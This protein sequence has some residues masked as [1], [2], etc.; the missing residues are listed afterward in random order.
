MLSI[1][2]IVTS[3]MLSLCLVAISSDSVHAQ[4]QDTELT[5]TQKTSET[6]GATLV[7]FALNAHVNIAV[8][9]ESYHNDGMESERANALIQMNIGLLDHVGPAVIELSKYDESEG[10]D[11]DFLV[12]IAKAFKS[13]KAEAVALAKY[14]ESEDDADH[15]EFLKLQEKTQAEIDKMLEK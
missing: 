1:R 6:L 15:Q 14:I 7:S 8:V 13:I 2:S 9:G 3:V 10:E 5:Y 12:A 11:R 4:E